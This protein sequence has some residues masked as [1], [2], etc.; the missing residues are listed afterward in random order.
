VTFEIKAQPAGPAGSSSLY[1][2]S[3]FFW[4]TS[5]TSS[6]A[7][8]TLATTL[9]GLVCG[10]GDIKNAK[11][12]FVLRDPIGSGYTI[13]AG[14]QNLPVNYIDPNNKNEGTAGVVVQYNIG[15]ATSTILNLGVIVSGSYTAN[16]IAFDQPVTISKPVKEGQ[17]SGGAVLVQTPSTTGFIM[18]SSTVTFADIKYNKAKTAIQGDI[19]IK[20]T[21]D[22]NENGVADGRTH[23][24]RI[25]T[26]AITVLTNTTGT[27]TGTGTNGTTAANFGSKANISEL[28]TDDTPTAERGL[29][30]NGERSIEGNCTMIMDIKDLATECPNT[31]DLIKVTIQRNKGGVW[32]ATNWTNGQADYQAISNG[33]IVYGTAPATTTSA[34]TPVTGVPTLDVAPPAGPA[35][36]DDKLT[37]NA[38]PNPSISQFN[39]KLGSNSTQGISVRVTDISGRLI[40]VKQSLF[41][42]QTI[43]IGGA[44]R[45]GVYIVDVIQGN[46]RKQVKI[47]KS[48]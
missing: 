13:I 47:I 2:G 8:L 18:G 33:N 14:A 15:S 46:N 1:T 3:T 5:A 20:V 31:K 30:S 40:E 6:T 12:T 45:S 7:T 22:R 28:L 34:S 41:P 38:F 4:T 17:L 29:Y 16:S 35:V 10:E 25:K 24:Y 36:R 44:Y 27:A 11:V 9:K 32:Y 43:Q 42:G 26:N 48:N 39:L 19:Q 23:V 21:S 37:V